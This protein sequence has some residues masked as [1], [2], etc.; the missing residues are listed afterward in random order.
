ATLLILNTLL[1]SSHSAPATN[2][3]TTWRRS[4]PQPPRTRNGA[5]AALS[6]VLALADQLRPAIEQGDRARQNAIV[7]ELIDKRAPMGGQWQ[8]LALLVLGNG[9]IGLARQAV[10]LLVEALGG[11]HAAH[12]HKAALLALLSDWQ[13]ADAT[14]RALPEDVPDPAAN[15]YSRGMAALNLGAL[16]K[17]QHHL[18]RTTR[19]RPQAGRAWLA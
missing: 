13:G 8:Q 16:E 11:D 18:E 4:V 19:L 5:D 7:R 6:A 3:S 1:L 17:A 14:L 10:D 2:R 15:A 9:E 12:Y